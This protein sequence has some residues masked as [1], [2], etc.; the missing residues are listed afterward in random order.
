MKILTFIPVLLLVGCCSAVPPKIINHD[1]IVTVPCKITMPT[2]PSMP[3]TD[4]GNVSDD[5]FVKSQKALAEIDLRK[6]YESQLE[7]GVKSCE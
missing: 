1:V 6:G 3:L 5:I 2:K 7:A 4:S